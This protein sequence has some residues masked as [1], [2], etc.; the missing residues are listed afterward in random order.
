MR[1]R[2]RGSQASAEIEQARGENREEEQPE[3]KG[4][5]AAYAVA[6]SFGGIGGDEFLCPIDQGLSFGP[7]GLK[8]F[9]AD[10]FSVAEP[11]DFG[12]DQAFEFIEAIETLEVK[13]LEAVT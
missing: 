10:G 8:D 6:N 1:W 13:G 9:R 2:N 12:A 11:E 7:D 3:Q 5:G 4:E